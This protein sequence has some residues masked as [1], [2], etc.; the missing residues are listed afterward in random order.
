VLP[1]KMGG[2]LNIVR[3]LLDARPSCGMPYDVVLTDNR[4]STDTR[5]GGFLEAD[6]QTTV[7]YAL[8]VENIY[9][10]LRRLRRA[11]PDGGGVLVSNDLLELAMLHVHD[12]GMMVVQVLH[13][14]HTYYYDL[15]ERHQGVIDVFVA[16]S[17]AM[18]EQLVRRLPARS[19]DILHLPY[20]VPLPAQTRVARAGPLRLVF[21]G[22]LEHGQKGVFDLPR[23]DAALAARGVVVEWTIIGGGPD[24][25]ALR[26]QWQ[27][28]HVT[29]GGV[30][31][32]EQTIAKLAD[33]DVFVLPTRREGFP[34]ALVEAMA[35]GLVPVVSDIASGVPEVVTDGETGI[36]R[37]VGDVDAFARA[38]ASLD[39]D[40]GALDR[41]STAARDTVA[42]NFGLRTTAK[43]YQQLFGEWRERRRPRHASPLPYGSRLDQPW[44]P[45]PVVR[46]VRSVVRQWQG[47]PW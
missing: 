18:Y 41:M 34:V 9:A 35:S 46:T 4:L 39:A 3:G 44:M 40:R 10:V 1:D 27:A 8:P 33:F 13:G 7:H 32:H 12:P 38:I 11:L 45:N 22:R 43:A 15:A 16:Y 6:R 20:G 31:T 19:N 36:R 21:A 47:K 24:E 17:R 2:V 25:R 14:D 5:F 23:I 29:W 42:R 30:L 37:P 28:P 26:E